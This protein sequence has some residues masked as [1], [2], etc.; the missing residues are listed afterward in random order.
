MTPR[1]V[2]VR[3]IYDDPA[4][5]DGLRILVDRVWPR[6]L[7]KEAARHADPDDRDKRRRT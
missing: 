6:G 2:Q 4:A 3:R 1:N 5:D 7:R